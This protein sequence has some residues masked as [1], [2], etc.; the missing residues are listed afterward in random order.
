MEVKP[1]AVDELA[2]LCAYLTD[3]A[4]ELRGQVSEDENGRMILP[5]GI[6]ESFRRAHLGFEGASGRYAELGGRYGR[7]KAVLLSHFWSYTGVSGMYFPFTAEAN[8]NI[9]MPHYMIP[10]STLHEMAHQRGFASLIII[11]TI[12]NITK[13]T[14]KTTISSANEKGNKPVKRLYELMTAL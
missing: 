2:E 5:D 11:L 4:N 12:K 3:K 8:I 6:S 14:V 7:P 13:N 9:K 10:S 1:A